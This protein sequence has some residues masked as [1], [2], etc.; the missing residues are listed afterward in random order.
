MVGLDVYIGINTPKLSVPENIQVRLN[1]RHIF[2]YYGS[3][4][5]PIL[6]SL[7]MST[8]ILFFNYK[9]TSIEIINFSIFPLKDFTIKLIKSIFFDRNNIMNKITPV[10]RRLDIV[11]III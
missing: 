7:K 1:V 8:L 5:G 3:V 6:F 10:S 11:C 2:I 9:Q 4:L